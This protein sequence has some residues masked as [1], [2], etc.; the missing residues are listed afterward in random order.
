MQQYRLGIDVGG[1]KIAYGLFDESY[2]LVSRL[3][4]PSRPEL[5]AEDMLDVLL[6]RY[7]TSHVVLTLGE[8]GS[9]YAD[10][11][12]RVRQGA[13]K[14]TA[15]DTTAAGDTFTGYFLHAMLQGVDIQQAL[16]TAAQASAIAVSRPG[17]GKSIPL[18]EEVRKALE[19]AGNA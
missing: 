3:T 8:H 16:R 1:T 5:S 18:A 17:A 19:A 11:Q 4:T 15:V 2:R 9:I 14:C 13:I 7:P 10:A 6:R 12:R